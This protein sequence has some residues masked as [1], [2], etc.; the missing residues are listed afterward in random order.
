MSL[1]QAATILYTSQLPCYVGRCAMCLGCGV[2]SP[3]CF[4]NCKHSG[5]PDRDRLW[6]CICVCVCLHACVFAHASVFWSAACLLLFLVV[7]REIPLLFLSPIMHC[8][9]YQAAQEVEKYWDV[10]PLH[11]FHS[12]ICSLF[13]LHCVSPFLSLPCAPFICSLEVLSHLQLFSV[14]SLLFL[15]LLVRAPGSVRAMSASWVVDW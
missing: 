4:S 6:L 8:C 14:V 11:T 1:I 2:S 5:I 13:F 9:L 10:K 3:G 7:I 12:P 15:V